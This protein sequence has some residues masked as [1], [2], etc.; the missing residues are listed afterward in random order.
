MKKHT[1]E[2]EV[3][4][5]IK[6]LIPRQYHPWFV[7]LYVKYEYSLIKFRCPFCSGHFRKLLPT[8]YYVPELRTKNITGGGYRLNVKCPGCLSSDRERLIFLYLKNRTS[9]FS[10]N[11][12]MLHVAPERNLQKVLLAHPNIDY[13]SVDLNSPLAI[14][15]MDI[16]N[17]QYEDNSFDVIICNHVL[18]HIPDDRKAM[19]ELH[20]VLKPG[21]CAILQVPVSQS[22]ITTHEDPSITAPDER[23]KAFGQSDHVRIYARDY[24]DRLESVG[25]SVQVYSFLREFGWLA[26]HKYALLK[27]ENV[28]IGTK[29]EQ[30]TV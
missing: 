4:S 5:L 7:D 3:K 1:M 27:D 21:G 12:R 23:E 18:E 26:V 19:S 16:T 17:I 13:L 22:L 24:R 25:F 30:G 10:E 2:Q 8:G 15:Q 29:P 14:V 6:K 28:Y 20:R 9:V 11:L